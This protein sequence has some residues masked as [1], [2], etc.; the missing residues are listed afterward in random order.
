MEMMKGTP[1][2]FGTAHGPIVF[3]SQ[4][5]A[6]PSAPV[7]G[8]P[9]EETRRWEEACTEANRQLEALRQE[10]LESG[11]EEAAEILE[12]QQLFLEDEDVVERVA[13]ELQGG[14]SAQTAAGRA[15]GALQK[16]LRGWKSLTCRPDPPMYG[17][18]GPDS[19]TFSPGERVALPG[20][21][22]FPAPAF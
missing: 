18:F 5:Q 4:T 17:T 2:S 13:C 12:I 20:S 11:H 10:R 22:S 19:P 9:E 14:C 3:L 15:F 16:N 1:I 21:R 8:D 7:S 6:V